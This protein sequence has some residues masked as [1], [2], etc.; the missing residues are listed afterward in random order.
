MPKSLCSVSPRKM[1]VLFHRESANS[2]PSPHSSSNN[3]SQESLQKQ[4]KKKGIKGSIGR[5]FLKK[6][7]SRT[8]P[9]DGAGSLAQDIHEP[10]ASECYVLIIDYR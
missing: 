5:I 1:G 3:S 2:S 9:R 4:Q 10:T 6:E 7:R 8:L